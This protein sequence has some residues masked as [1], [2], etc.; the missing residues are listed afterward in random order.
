MGAVVKM[1]MN[2]QK[3]DAVGTAAL[4]GVTAAD[5]ESLGLLWVSERRT[6]TPDTG[7][8]ETGTTPVMGWSKSERQLRWKGG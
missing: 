1:M 3:V 4:Q 5:I 7:L 2:Q 8:R 6:D